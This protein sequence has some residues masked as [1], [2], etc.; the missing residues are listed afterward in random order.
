[1]KPACATCFRVVGAPARLLIF[2]ALKSN[3]RRYDV[4]TLVEITG[5]KQPT[6]TFHI[7]R[8]AKAGLVKKIREGRNVYA[9]AVRKCAD[10]PLY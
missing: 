7:N 8:L 10:C 5:L 1:M 6:V 9:I 2:N 4:S 3:D